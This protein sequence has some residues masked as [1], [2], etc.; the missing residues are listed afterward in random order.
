MSRIPIG[1][2]GGAWA[3]DPEVATRTYFVPQG[4]SAD[5]I[6][7]LKGYTRDE[8]DRFA[9]ESQRRAAEAQRE[10]RFARSLV[11]VAGIDGHV[12]LDRDSTHAP[13]PARAWPE[14]RRSPDRRRGRVRR[15]S[16]RQVPGARGLESRPPCR[17]LQRDRGRGGGAILVGSEARRAPVGS[18]AR[19]HRRL[20]D[21]VHRSDDHA[22]GPRAGDPQRFSPKP[23]CRSTEIDLFESQ[24]AFAA[25][26]LNFMDELHVPRQVSV[27]GGSIALGH[28]LGRP[29]P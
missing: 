2:D 27:N 15:G 28:P 17:Q 16:A 21:H 4:I 8:V 13:G 6:A 26:V 29:A 18:V 25:V 20:C 22:D 5:L 1:S 7:T 3:V 11:P 24:Q 19:P 12:L 14:R 23:A 10:N 9:L